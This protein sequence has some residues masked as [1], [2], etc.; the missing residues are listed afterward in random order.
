MKRFLI[1]L[2]G[3]MLLAGQAFAQPMIEVNPPELNFGEVI[4]GNEVTQELEISNVGN[5]P[6]LFSVFTESP[7]FQFDAIENEDLAPRH[8][9]N[10]TVVFAPE[11]MGFYT[12][13]LVFL[14]NAPEHE[15]FEIP[16]TGHAMG[17][18]FEGP[19]FV[20]PRFVAFGP[21]LVGERAVREIHLVNRG[22]ITLTPVIT[23]EGEAFSLPEM[24]PL[25]LEPGD[26]FTMDVFFQPDDDVFYDGTVTFDLENPMFDDVVVE[27]SGSGFAPLEGPVLQ[28]PQNLGFGPVVVG[29][30][31]DRE[32]RILNIGTETL[33]VSGWTESPGFFAEGFENMEIEPGDLFTVTVTFSPEEV[34]HY[35]GDFLLLSNDP[36]HEEVH[37]GLFGMGIDEGHEEGPRIHAPEFIPFGR[38]PVGHEAERNLVIGNRGNEVLEVSGMLDGDGFFMEPFEGLEIAPGTMIE[39]P[40]GFG[41]EEP[42]EYEGGI[43]LNSNDPEHPE[44]VVGLFAV[45]YAVEEGPAIEVAEG[46]N[47]G[48][49]PVGQ[50]THRGLVIFSVGT[51]DLVV[52]LSLESEVF[53]LEPVDEEIVL[54][55]DTRETFHINFTPPEPGEYGGELVIN[56]N[57]P[58]QEVVIVELFGQGA[59]APE[60]PRIAVAE[61]IG[62]GPVPLG[63][64][65]TRGLIVHNVGNEPLIV[66]PE[67]GEGDFHIPDMDEFT[68][69]PFDQVEFPVTFA[70]REAGM[71]E[72]VL[73]LA[74]N[75]P[76]RPVVEIG[77]WG[78]GLGGEEGMI[79]VPE[80]IHFGQTLVG[81]DRV[82][83]LTVSNITDHAVWIGIMV[84]GDG[85]DA[86]P[87]GELRLEGGEVYEHPIIFS[88]PEPG[89]FGGTALVTA[90]FEGVTETYNVR[91]DGVGVEELN[92]PEIHVSPEALLFGPVPVGTEMT[93]DLVVSNMGN[94]E[95]MFH[96]V[97][98]GDAFT[99]PPM[100]PI[101]VEPEGEYVLPVTFHPF[102][103]REYEAPLIIESNDPEH[104]RIV[105]GMAGV[106]VDD[107]PWHPRFQT[108]PPTG[109]PYL[110]IVDE[111]YLDEEPLSEGDEI[112][113][114]DGDLCVGADVVPG[115]WPLPITTWQGAPDQ[116]LDGFTPGNPIYF[117]IWGHD[118]QEPFVAYPEFTQGNGTFG[119]GVFTEVSIAG[120]RTRWIEIP[121]QPNYFELVSFHVTPLDL[122]AEEVFGSLEHLVIAYQ[123]DGDIYL[124]PEINTI[125]E[126]DATQ[127]YRIFC[128]EPDQLVTVGYP[129]DPAGTDYHLTAGPWN[130]LGYPFPFETPV[131]VVLGPLA[132]QIVI[133][134]ADD[135]RAWIPSININ[136]MGNMQP[137]EG[138]MVVVNDDV[139][140][141]YILPHDGGLFSAS[142][143]ELVVAPDAPSATG[144]P[145][146]VVVRLNDDLAASGPGE[147]EIYDGLRL[148]G[149]SIVTDETAPVPVVT[150]QGDDARNLQGFA[151]GNPMTIV[152]KS[153]S[154]EI[155]NSEVEGSTVH[156]GEGAYA[157]V[158]LSQK[159]TVLPESFNVGEAYPNPFN[160]SVTIPFSL[161]Q[162]GS[163]QFSLYNVLGQQ[164]Y[165]A[166]KYYEA[167]AHQFLFDASSINQNLESGLYFLRVEFQEQTTTRKLLL[168]K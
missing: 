157:D 97:S 94:S 70:P 88:P 79:R 28:A 109:L 6:L 33:V 121:I 158:T 114:F 111:A 60:G 25:T 52:S 127:G 156:F 160:P 80:V 13:D 166:T 38:V 145:Y 11:E 130:W 81:E 115:E 29:D 120:Y 18:H 159:E 69:D 134:M 12:G 104:P 22:E 137:G 89:E 131:E 129:L 62:F 110:V 150:W 50:E 98:Q 99:V 59:E 106:G 117:L 154:G 27:L 5:E 101:L 93:M 136:T 39:I 10:V 135:G 44:I 90:S 74:S 51:E 152:V 143:N 147:I 128:N 36:E 77:L 21:V 41:V 1:V 85:F 84:E 146:M 122:A 26:E 142:G 30:E 42:G 31:Y 58:D 23:V 91:L 4:V 119:F 138:F 103:T 63:D 116:G 20:M 151:A 7:G 133:V 148:V 108:V 55:P 124:P 164:T 68:V 61:G 64:E 73:H 53:S 34:G 118:D 65:V 67:I 35:N 57:I 83:T 9:V 96:A 17:N 14:S 153:S 78:F 149:K 40:V 76:E 82:R 112:G 161:P 102:D 16:M 3:L 19:L 165:T 49:V 56:T 155:L 92:A 113:I 123:N 141:N 107:N 48:V 75:D 72:G 2:T 132:E 162:A 105:I 140:F 46:V 87:L 43:V 71:H 15:R 163:V 168:V 37:V 125:G 144:L 45:A 100:E 126:I 47:F 66:H 54:P 8:S 32:L 95:L 139:T 86:E 167:G 24:D